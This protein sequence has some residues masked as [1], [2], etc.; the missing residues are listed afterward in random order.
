[1]KAVLRVGG[2]QPLVRA[3]GFYQ[4]QLGSIAQMRRQLR[5]RFFL[6]IE[7]VPVAGDQGL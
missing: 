3:A 5:R 7:P 2:L 4:C 1:M 6:G